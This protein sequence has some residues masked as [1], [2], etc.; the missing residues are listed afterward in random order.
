MQDHGRPLRRAG[1]QPDERGDDPVDGVAE[2]E[3]F[4]LGERPPHRVHVEAD[5]DLDQARDDGGLVGD[6]L[7]ER[8]DRD[9]GPLGDPRRRQRVVALGP[10]NLKRRL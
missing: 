4:G 2:V 6:V 8:A 10:Q 7:V 9:A 5:L 1:E 3:R